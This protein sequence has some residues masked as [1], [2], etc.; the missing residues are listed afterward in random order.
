MRPLTSDR[1]RRHRHVDTSCRSTTQLR[2]VA[3]RYEALPGEPLVVA[4]EEGV[5]VNDL[6]PDQATIQ[7]VLDQDAEQGR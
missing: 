6:N 7:A 4:A 5:L 2:R 1:A 3:D